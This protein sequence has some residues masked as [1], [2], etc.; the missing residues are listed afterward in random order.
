MRRRLAIALLVLGVGIGLG[1][2][3]VRD[4]VAHA[5]AGQT[6]VHLKAAF[7]RT[8]HLASDRA[9]VVSGPLRCTPRG[10]AV[11]IR[12]TLVRRTQPAPA[13]GT[14]SWR[15]TCGTRRWKT[16]IASR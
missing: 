9:A 3:V 5:T 10:A 1:A 7:D 8:A 4:Q 16:T 15:G 14:A 13:F 2:T 12:V 11:T 6:T